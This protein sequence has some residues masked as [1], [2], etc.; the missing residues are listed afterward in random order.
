MPEIAG[1]ATGSVLND[2]RALIF[3]S[4][5]GIDLKK[6]FVWLPG[7]S[8]AEMT[9]HAYIYDPNRKEFS[10]GPTQSIEVKPPQPV[11]IDSTKVLILGI[12]LPDYDDV[13]SSEIY[14]SGTNQFTAF[15]RV[16]RERMDFSATR[17]AD[18]SVLIAG[19]M[20]SSLPYDVRRSVLFCP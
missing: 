20:A 18:G 11:A 15:G 5:P 14:D 19:G 8:K 16:H 9:W 4:I 10:P 6:H 7:L 12:V 13:L 17:L 2:G 3:A 1:Y